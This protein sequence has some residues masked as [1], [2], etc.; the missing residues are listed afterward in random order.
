M[1]G[2][3]PFLALLAQVVPPEKVT[4]A[5]DRELLQNLPDQT[6]FLGLAH[7]L[8]RVRLLVLEAGE[9]HGAVLHDF[10]CALVVPGGEVPGEGS[11]EGRQ[12]LRGSHVSGP[13]ALQQDPEGLLVQV[14]P[15]RGVTGDAAEDDANAAAEALDELALGGALPGP[16]ASN[17]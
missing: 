11:D 1:V 16:D 9:T 5:L 7:P 3:D 14:I 17:Q 15:D 4:V 2:L 8:Q 6:D 10:A 12:L 13:E